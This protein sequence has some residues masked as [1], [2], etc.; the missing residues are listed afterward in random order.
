MESCTYIVFTH[1][2]ALSSEVKDQPP[3]SW[4]SPG[5]ALTKSLD[6]TLPSFSGAGS[7]FRNTPKS[8]G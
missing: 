4:N 7:Q 6:R 2:G 1:Y 8:V 5:V 3:K